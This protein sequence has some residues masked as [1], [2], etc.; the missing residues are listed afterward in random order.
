MVTKAKYVILKSKDK[1]DT[2]HF[3]NKMTVIICHG[4]EKKT[5]DITLA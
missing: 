2:F 1:E 3:D 5:F 4:Q